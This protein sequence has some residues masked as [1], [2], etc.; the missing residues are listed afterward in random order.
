VDRICLLDGGTGRELL[1]IGAPFGLPEWSAR[2][3]RDGPQFVTRVHEAFVAAGADVITTN[4]YAVVPY[5]LGQA[6]FEAEGHALAA[7]SGRLAREVAD[8]SSRPVAVA[9]CLPPLCGSYHA[10]HYDTAAARPILANLVSAL[11]PSIDHWL[12]ETLSA[13]FEAELVF[14]LVGA[15]GKPLWLSFTLA[16]DVGP[17]AVARLRS[18]E[19]VS[20]AVAAAVRLGAAAVLFNCSRPEVMGAAVSEAARLRAAAPGKPGAWQIGVYANA[21]VPHDSPGEANAVLSDLRSDVSP[22]AYLDW[23]RDWVARGARIIGGC[24]GIGP[25]HIARLRSLNAS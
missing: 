15:A 18:G 14:E 5:H 16:E 8:R 10:D 25:E 20:E 13:M 2:A 23:A 11:A 24:C 4:S 17:A 21:F 3:L 9:G 6:R 12:A 19:R 1:R 7:L 22:E